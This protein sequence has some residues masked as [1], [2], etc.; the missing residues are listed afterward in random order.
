VTHK[1]EVKLSIR[2]SVV[3]SFF[4][5]ETSI[6]HSSYNALKD[7]IIAFVSATCKQSDINSGF[8]LTTYDYKIRVIICCLLLNI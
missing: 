4:F 6:L 8:V 3:F 2:K 7:P 1:T 5:N